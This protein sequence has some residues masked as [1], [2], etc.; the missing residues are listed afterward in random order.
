MFSFLNKTDNNSTSFPWKNV[1]SLDLLNSLMNSDEPILIFKHSTRCIISKT[2]KSRFETMANESTM[3][4]YLVLV[5]EE[6]PFSNHIADSSGITHQSPQALIFKGG[7][8]VY[9]ESHDEI[10]DERIMAHLL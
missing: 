5:I 2:V 3:D 7:K 4:M 8:C 1:E 10:L 6:R 9:D